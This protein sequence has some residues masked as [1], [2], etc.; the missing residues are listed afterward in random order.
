MFQVNSSSISEMA[1]MVAGDLLVAVNGEDVQTYRHKV[2][3]AGRN[4]MVTLKYYCRRPR[5]QL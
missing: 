1:G 3:S 5:T 4:T 2:T